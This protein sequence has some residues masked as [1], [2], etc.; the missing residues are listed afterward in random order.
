[1]KYLSWMEDKGFIQRDL[2]GNVSL[3]RKGAETYDELVKWILQ[4]VGKVR[5]TKFS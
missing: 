2:D 5:F 1:M 3:T 4:Y